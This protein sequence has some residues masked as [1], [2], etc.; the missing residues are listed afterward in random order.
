MIVTSSVVACFG[1][2]ILGLEKPRFKVEHRLCR[3]HGSYGR[4]RMLAMWHFV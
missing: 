1:L 4:L 2:C 3:A